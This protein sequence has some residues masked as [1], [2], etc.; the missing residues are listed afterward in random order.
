MSLDF[1]YPRKM[2]SQ[3]Q[4]SQQHLRIQMYENGQYFPINA[5]GSGDEMVALEDY[6]EDLFGPN[7]K[8]LPEDHWYDVNTIDDENDFL[9]Y[10]VKPN[11]NPKNGSIAESMIRVDFTDEIRRKWDGIQYRLDK[12]KLRYSAFEGTVNLIINMENGPVTEADKA[13]AVRKAKE[14]SLKVMEEALN[15]AINKVTRLRKEILELRKELG[16]DLGP[17]PA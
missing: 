13:V 4:Q 5:E 1:G 7:S 8:E 9:I 14:D 2:A 3:K 12:S 11:P 6:L 10:L 15:S 16:L 17:G